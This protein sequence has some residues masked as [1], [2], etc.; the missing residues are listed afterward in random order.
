MSDDAAQKLRVIHD[1]LGIDFVGIARAC[2][3]DAAARALE[4]SMAQTI[5]ITIEDGKSTIETRGFSGKAC[6]DAT[7]EL[8]KAMGAKTSDRKTPEFDVKEVR[9]IGS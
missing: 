9:T 6:M 5:T 2:G 4:E 3:N 8:E 7:A 1:A